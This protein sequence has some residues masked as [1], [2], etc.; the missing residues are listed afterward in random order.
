MHPPVG[1]WTIAIGEYAFGLTPFGWRFAMAVL[2][3]LAVLL[4]VRITRRLTRSTL[5]GG[6]AGLL[7]AI[8]GIADRDVAARR[9]STTP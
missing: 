7:I 9:C 2:G 4:A 6:I 1:K 3:T 8:D 5:I